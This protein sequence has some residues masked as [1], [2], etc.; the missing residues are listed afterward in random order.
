MNIGV[1]GC[2]TFWRK[3]LTFTGTFVM[4][5]ISFVIL[6]GLSL[7]QV[8]KSAD[9]AIS[10]AIS[11]VIQVINVVITGTPSLIFSGDCSIDS[12][13]KKLYSDKLSAQSRHED[14]F[15]SAAQ[16]DHRAYNR[17]LLHQEQGLRNW[18]PHRRRVLH[19]SHQCHPCST[20]EVY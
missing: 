11:I 18:W 19:G 4:L 1:P 5:G 6:Y 12:K 2:E 17:Q 20:H 10:I 8:Q 15:R 14:Y 3:F 16:H 13:G 7:A 9:I